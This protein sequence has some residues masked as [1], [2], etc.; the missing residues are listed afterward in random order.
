[1]PKKPIFIREKTSMAL[2]FIN[3]ANRFYYQSKKYENE[4]DEP[5]E[6]FNAQII[7]FRI[8]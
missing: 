5:N 8:Q 3:A 6:D 2:F 1:M 7:S 4:N